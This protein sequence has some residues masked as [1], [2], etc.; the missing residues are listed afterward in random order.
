MLCR[1]APAPPHSRVPALPN[2]LAFSG[3]SLLQPGY[4]TRQ[5]NLVKRAL[6]LIYG[7]QMGK[8]V[9]K[10]FG[11]RLSEHRVEASPPT[12]I[13]GPNR[14]SGE[15]K[16]WRGVQDR[17]GSP[18]AGWDNGRQTAGRLDR[19]TAGLEDG[20]HSTRPTSRELRAPRPRLTSAHSPG[21]P[22]PWAHRLR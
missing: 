8:V 13:R 16:F 9:K 6:L 12:Y 21:R 10:S 4:P 22:R 1:A 5:R 18:R 20:T 17:L 14:K 19:K 7:V 15:K 3:S 2:A 11:A